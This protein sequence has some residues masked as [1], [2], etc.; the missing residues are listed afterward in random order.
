[1]TDA[2]SPH[3]DSSSTMTCFVCD[4]VYVHVK[5]SPTDFACCPKCSSQYWQINSNMKDPWFLKEARLRA[6]EISTA[7]KKAIDKEM[8]D[9][10]GLFSFKWHRY[11]VAAILVFCVILA[12]VK[13]PR[14]F[15]IALLP[16][17]IIGPIILSIAV[18]MLLKK[19]I[20]LI[21]KHPTFSAA[22][23]LSSMMLVASF[24][25]TPNTASSTHNLLYAPP[26]NDM[27]GPVTSTR[28]P[29]KTQA[30]A[31]LIPCNKTRPENLERLKKP[32]PRKN[33]LA[34]CAE[35]THMHSNNQGKTQRKCV[36]ADHGIKKKAL[37]SLT[38]PMGPG[39]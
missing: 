26:N 15:I 32:A 24:W 25:F 31:A 29:N 6:K 23:L 37:N 13:D 1:M 20:K 7:G 3:T 17:V 14:L 34:P 33:C 16:L 27:P 8:V 22:L 21:K 2:G 28:M 10:T 38:T 35:K 5:Q 11:L 39:R 12:L 18:N 9:G 4:H 19:I 36:R 30:K